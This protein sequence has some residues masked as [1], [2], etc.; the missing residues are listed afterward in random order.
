LHDLKKAGVFGYT[1]H[2]DTSQKRPDSPVDT[3]AGHNALRQRLAEMLAAEGGIACSF[4][5]TVVDTSLDQ[6]PD[7]VR[8][9][10]KHPDIV[11][12]VVFILYREPRLL[13]GFDFFAKG[14]KVNA[15]DTYEETQWGGQKVLKA[16]DV[17]DRIRQVDPLY[18]P[19][20]YLN[21]TCD[22]QSTK[23]LLGSCVANRDET[24][25]YVS[26]KFMELVQHGSHWLRRKWLSYSDPRF[27]GHARTT[28]LALAPV[29]RGMRQIAGRYLR[30]LLRHPTRLFQRAYL[31]T[32]T[33][34]QPVDFMADG[35]MNMCDGCPDMTVHQGKLYW[36]CRLEEIKRYGAFLTAAPK[37]RLNELR[38]PQEAT[39]PGAVVDPVAAPTEPD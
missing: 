3:E 11:H 39:R 8:W 9:A 25:G 5:Q 24:F 15:N 14:V 26:P 33:I 12:T 16:Q 17:V 7:V 1:F 35:R 32:F 22:A 28:A 31:Q 6:V 27:L 21:G 4:N 2:I 18:E 10:K 23:W 29:E 19:C 20:A 34:I 36:S 13:A 37:R 38:R 30:W